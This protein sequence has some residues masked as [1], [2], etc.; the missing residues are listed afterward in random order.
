MN[1]LVCCP[2]NIFAGR[3]S[4]FQH[5]EG[6]WGR[7]FPMSGGAQRSVQGEAF[8]HRESVV[9]HKNKER[10]LSDTTLGGKMKKNPYLIHILM[11]LAFTLFLYGCN[12]KKAEEVDTEN[13][14]ENARSTITLS[15]DALKIAGIKTDIVQLRTVSQRIKVVGEISF[16][17]RKFVNITSRVSGRVEEVFAFPGDK[18]KEGQLLLSIYSPDFL[19]AQAEFIQAE[20]RLKRV[21]KNNDE[22]ER[23][24]A[25]SLLDSARNKLILLNIREEELIELEKTHSIKFLL[26]IRA[27]FNGSIIESNVVTGDYI[28]TGTSLFKIADISTLWVNVNIY[29]KDLSSIKQGCKTLIRVSAFPNEEFKGKLTL[30]SDVVDKN[31]RTVKGRVE[32]MNKSGKL[33]PGMYAEVNLIFP[34]ESKSLLIPEIAVQD[35]EGKKVV[36]LQSGNNSFS[37]KEIETGLKLDS[38]IEIVNGLKTGDIIATEGSFILK[39]ELLKKTLERGSVDHFK[40]KQF[41]P[42]RSE[43]AWGRGFPM[44]GGCSAKRLRGACPHRESVMSQESNEG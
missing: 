13:A 42:Q 31:T 25:K 29:E 27:P 28:D 15:E 30:L 40:D 4:L 35:L 24:N 18:V 43:G 6:V 10:Y 3:R 9:S 38:F 19:S 16:N 5:T 11:I 1:N 41:F 26:P 21:M 20:E 33:K 37:V 2:L 39:S 36:F 17:Q 34:S 44:S 12:K 8:S 23:Q 22:E 14:E 32:V 7:G